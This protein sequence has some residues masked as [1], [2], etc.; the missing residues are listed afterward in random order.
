[1][2][3]SAQASKKRRRMTFLLGLMTFTLIYDLVL[4]PL[5]LFI[6]NFKDITD[7]MFK[8]PHIPKIMLAINSVLNSLTPNFLI[9]IF[10]IKIDYFGRKATAKNN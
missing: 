10:L 7:D 1:M 3:E 2:L 6:F 5:F 4:Y 9:S 8:H